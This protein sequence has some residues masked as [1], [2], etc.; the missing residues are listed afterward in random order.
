VG[1]LLSARS[2]ETSELEIR[3]VLNPQ[4][5]DPSPKSVDNFLK[6]VFAGEEKELKAQ[7][8]ATMMTGYGWT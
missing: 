8:F 2:K 4:R 3:E 1:V 6:D 5:Q 7:R